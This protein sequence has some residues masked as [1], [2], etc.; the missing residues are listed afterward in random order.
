MI[1]LKGGFQGLVPS[2]CGAYEG[3]KAG[4]VLAAVKV[5]E[6]RVTQLFQEVD[7]GEDRRGYWRRGWRE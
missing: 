7:T 3:G 5:V 4:Q 1:G 6:K 2:G